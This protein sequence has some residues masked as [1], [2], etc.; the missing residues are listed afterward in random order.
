MAAP[1]QQGLSVAGI[2]VTDAA[3]CDPLADY[4]LGAGDYPEA[5]RLHALIVARHPNNA[6]AHYH[7][8][9]AFGLEGET[10]SEIHE[11]ER[12]VALGLRIFDLFL[13]L[14]VARFDRGDLVGA[15]EAFKQ[16]ST[17]T[18]RP[19]VNFDLALVYERRAML[20]EAESEILLA[21]A[22]NPNAIE[23]LNVRAAIAAEKGD[24]EKARD[25][26][27]AILSRHP[28]YAPAL[29]NLQTLRV[30]HRETA[31]RKPP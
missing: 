2:W 23:Y 19:E 10:R 8:G 4:F 25:I 22:K 11:Y 24:A 28:Q 26:W 15:T 9:F 17:L 29:A 7:L 27:I 31:R 12:A 3:I 30:L 16:A 5:I 20:P 13:N 21:L 14:G 1:G 18:D 6:L